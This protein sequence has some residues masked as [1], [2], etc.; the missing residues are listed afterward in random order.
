MNPASGSGSVQNSDY[1]AAVNGFRAAGGKV[2]GYVATGYGAR[3]QADVL[4][5]VTNY[6][7]FYN[8]DGIFLDEMSNQAGDLGY[9]QAVYNNIKGLN[10][11]YKV[12]GNAGTNTLEAYLTAADVLITFENQTGYEAYVPDTWTKNYT[13]DRFAHLMYNVGS[14]SSML[15]YIALAEQRNVGY[16]Y[17]T[18]DNNSNPNSA[19]NPW[20]TLPSYWEQEVSVKATPLP[21]S[22]WLLLSTLFV[23]A[24]GRKHTNR[25]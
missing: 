25:I 23:F 16:V 2:I 7:S 14:P 21:P 8:V 24:I 11:A 22:A 19:N 9:Y 20:D 13:A 3:S 4:T 1:V 15:Y 17:V 5:E 10:N 12:F 6:Q 18:D